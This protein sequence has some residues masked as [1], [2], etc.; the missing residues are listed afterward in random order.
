MLT[1]LIKDPTFERDCINVET[2]NILHHEKHRS[3]YLQGNGQYEV[4]NIEQSL[5]ALLMLPEVVMVQTEEDVQ[6]NH[7]RY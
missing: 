1:T 7:D 6:E 2:V 4:E 3:C 5:S